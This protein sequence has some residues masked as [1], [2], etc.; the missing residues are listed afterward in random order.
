MI[1]ED[2]LVYAS[3]ALAHAGRGPEYMATFIKGE[4]VTIHKPSIQKNMPRQ[5]AFIG[6]VG[7]VVRVDEDGAVVRWN[8]PTN[9]LWKYPHHE[10]EYVPVTA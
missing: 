4:R 5:V 8:K 7:E 9:F 6:C 1:G 10:L 2:A 3:R